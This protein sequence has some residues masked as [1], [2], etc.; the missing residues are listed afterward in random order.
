MAFHLVQAWVWPAWGDDATG[1]INDPTQPF[2]S[3]QAAIDALNDHILADSDPVKEGL[4]WCMPGV[5]GPTYSANHGPNASG[6][7][8]PILMRNRV[9]VRGVSARRCIIRGVNRSDPN[10]DD[11]TLVA[12]IYAGDLATNCNGFPVLPD[13][14][15]LVSYRYADKYANTTPGGGFHW[16][17]AVA[18]VDEILDGFTFQGGDIQVSFDTPQAMTRPQTGRVSNCIF[19]MRHMPE[20]EPVDIEGP[21]IGLLLS[22]NY[23]DRPPTYCGYFDQK[24]F[25]ANN[26]FIL[27][28]YNNFLWKNDARTG[29]V[30]LLNTSGLNDINRENRGLANLGLSNNIFRTRPANLPTNT[31]TM[32]MLGIDAGDCMVREEGSGAPFVPTN[33]FA[34]ARVGSTSALFQ[35]T[36][37]NPVFIADIDVGG[38]LISPP[39]M[40]PLYYD[41]FYT[42]LTAPCGGSL[43]CTATPAAL[44]VPAVALWNGS[45]SP[46]N[47]H[48]PGFVGEFLVHQ[49]G[50]PVLGDYAD[51]RILPGSP[52]I[53][54]GALWEHNEFQNGAV[55]TDHH[56]ELL[57]LRQWDGEGWGNVRVHGANGFESD[58]GF[59]EVHLGVMAGSYANGS[60]S[61]NRTTFLNP[62]ATASQSERRILL[63]IT[64]A[65]STVIGSTLRVKAAERQIALPIPPWTM[66]AWS[67]Q[68]P[69]LA[70]PL[71]NGSLPVGYQTAYI[72]FAAERWTVGVTVG[73]V[74]SS[75]PAVPIPG[76]TKW[77]L[78][79]VDL[80]SDDE[81]A[82]YTSHFNS[83]FV[84]DGGAFA[85]ELRGNLQPEYR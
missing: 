15:V 68:P 61:H 11:D 38:G 40:E 80:P 12:G 4:V 82:N 73:M 81:G 56:H 59:D 13:R 46:S 19:D 64:A 70:S 26:T 9:H 60:N 52:L 16:W 5:Y 53:D 49:P 34:P 25:I 14:Q 29:A 76:Y 66:P 7:E 35:S 28:E 47:E 22:M 2:Q 65:G 45:A 37:M 42:I 27:A 33:A 30:G 75:A 83:Q 51:W 31:G 21:E 50:T 85:T 58:I 63:P 32:A 72:N 8:F 78:V 20:A 18:E 74:L 44:P 24:V 77:S 79:Q 39:Q 69:L 54:Q 1:A 57:S 23:D 6:D 62:S 71:V 55:F 3:I 36:P 48:D 17:A 84:L 10:F 41:F 67:A 43:P